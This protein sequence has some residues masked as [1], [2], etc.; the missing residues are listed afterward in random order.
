MILAFVGLLLQQAIAAPDT[1]SAFDSPATQALVERAIREGAQI[2][3]ELRDYRAE[4]RTQ[5]HLSFKAD[6]GVVGEL[7][8]SVDEFAGEVRWERSGRMRHWLRGHRLRLA[9]PAPYTVG[10]A[11]EDSWLI[12]HLYGSTIEVLRTSLGAASTRNRSARAIHPFSERGLLHYRYTAGDTIR[13]RTGSGT[14]TLVPIT[15]EPLHPTDDARALLVAG[16]FGIDVERA[17]VA[18]ARFGFVEP[19]RG[20]RLV[21]TGAFFELENALVQNRFWL[22]YR[23]RRELQA[24]SLLAG[25]GA[26]ARFVTSFSNYELNT[27]WIPRDDVRSAL[28]RGIIPGDSAFR[29]WNAP[30]GT[31]AAEYDVT[32]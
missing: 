22:P 30:V 2:P 28:I 16:S 17:A 1:L 9:A 31:G 29:G 10:T 19:S 8:I 7:P 27:G 14:V 5:L 13:I 21:E 32:D 4:A 6:S 18:R 26:V 3:L 12:P 11:V 15:V 24:T 20:L 25:G 23:Q